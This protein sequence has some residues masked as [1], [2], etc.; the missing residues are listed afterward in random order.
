MKDNIEAVRTAVKTLTESLRAQF[1]AGL[2]TER[3]YTRIGAMI[4][5]ADNCL[6]SAWA[7]ALTF[8]EARI[9]QHANDPRA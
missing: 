7:A 6:L 3:D 1:I 5:C 9:L 2:L 8:E 4:D